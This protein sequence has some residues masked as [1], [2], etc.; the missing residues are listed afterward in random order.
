MVFQPILG[1]VTE[2]LG[3]NNIV[4]VILAATLLGLI[5]TLILFKLMKWGKKRKTAGS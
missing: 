2:Y 1:Y 5:F 4:F 3:K